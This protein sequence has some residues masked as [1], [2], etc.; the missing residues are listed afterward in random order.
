MSLKPTIFNLFP[1]LTRY[2]A[3]HPYLHL[4]LIA[5]IGTD[6]GSTSVSTTALAAGGAS[7]AAATPVAEEKKEHVDAPR[8]GRASAAVLWQLFRH[9]GVAAAAMGR[10]RRCLSQ[11]RGEQ[12]GRKMKLGLGRELGH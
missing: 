10:W 2:P 6:G 1:T 8:R 12:V 7:V 5:N 11:A 9:G 3:L 4:H